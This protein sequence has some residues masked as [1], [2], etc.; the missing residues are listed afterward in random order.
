MT[1]E[2]FQRPSKSCTR[3]RYV[4]QGRGEDAHA[5]LR[6][7]A[8]F[9]VDLHP[10]HPAAGRGP[11]EHVAHELEPAEQGDAP[12]GPAR[13]GGG[14]IPAG[15]DLDEPR[16]VFS[17]DQAESRSG[18]PHA[19]LHLGADGDVLDEVA[20][21]VGEEAIPLVAGIEAHL[22]AQ[23]AG[24][25]PDAE[26][27]VGGGARVVDAA[28]DMLGSWARKAAPPREQARGGAPG[29]CRGEGRR[30]SVRARKPSGNSGA[31]PCPNPNP[32]LP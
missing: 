8:D 24:G 13:H 28:K 19:H 6:G 15:P 31:P 2:R 23:K 27:Q 1:S 25:D 18:D 26:R 17:A 4:P 9:A 3:R 16:R 29:P 22:L 21:Q 10:L 30:G 14:V 12:G 5:L 11:L 7:H 20:Q 32:P